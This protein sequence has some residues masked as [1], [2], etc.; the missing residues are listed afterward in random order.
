MPFA[1]LFFGL[2]LLIA[3]F[4]GKHDDLFDLLKDD[5]TGSNNFF[6]WVMAVVFLVALGN[7]ERLRPFTD[8]FLILI[9]IVIVLANDGLPEKFMREIKDGTK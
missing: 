8:A 3:G 4:R 5:F 1:L 6:V 2:V 9:V 7:I